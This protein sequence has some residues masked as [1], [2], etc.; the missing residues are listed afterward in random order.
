MVGGMGVCNVCNGDS[1]VALPNAMDSRMQ[2][3]LWLVWMRK[4]GVILLR[5]KVLLMCILHPLPQAVWLPPCC[6][7][8]VPQSQQSPSLGPRAA[9]API[10]TTGH[11]TARGVL[12]GSSLC[13]TCDKPPNRQCLQRH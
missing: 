6:A 8:G 2:G 11:N 7:C 9:Q 4:N 13:V 3:H 10:G 5:S 1:A 12:E